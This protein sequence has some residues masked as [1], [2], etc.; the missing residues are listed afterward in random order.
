MALLGIDLEGT[1]IAIAL[2]DYEG[3]IPDRETLVLDK[4]QCTEEGGYCIADADQYNT[5][6]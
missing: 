4:R 1:K 6:R 3:I 5:E 2:F